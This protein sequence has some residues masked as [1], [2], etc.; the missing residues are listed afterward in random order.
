MPPAENPS[1]S[2]LEAFDFVVVVLYVLV[3]LG[4]VYRA[5]RHQHNTDD[6]FLGSRKMP[7]MAVGLSIM[8]TL[9]SSLTYLGLTGEVVKNGIAAFMTQAAIIPAAPF[10]LFLF[11]PFF[12]R[13]RFTSAYEYL[14]HRFDFR[15]RLLGGGLF[16]LLRLLW[17]SMVMYSGSLALAN[18]GGWNFYGTIAILGIVATLY[19]YF[20]GLEG[21]IWTDVIQA[22]MLFGGAAAIVL[23][24]WFDTGHGPLAWWQVAG[25]HSA[26]HRQ[27]EWFSFDPTKRITLGTALIS[28]FFWQICTHCSDQVVLQRYAS[29]PS[30]AAAR[31]SY[32]T[33]VVA[34]LSIT[35]LLGVSGLALLYYYLQ[36]PDRLPAGLTATS[37][38]DKLMPHFYA[39]QL[40]LGFGGLILANFLCDAMQTLVSGVNSI[41]AVATQD[42]LEHAKAAREGVSNRLGL[43]RRLTLVLGGM[44][45]LIALGVAWL[46]EA[47]G[48]NIFELMP[49]TFNMFIGPLGSLFLI[50]MFLPRATGRTATPAVLGAVAVSVVWNYWKE[51]LSIPLVWHF[52]KHVVQQP[53][54]LSI[55]WAYA[56]AC[57]SGLVFAI[58]LSL[59]FDKGGDHP[60]RA[61]T[62]WAIMQRPLPAPTPE[63]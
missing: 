13:L 48:K 58:V 24:V 45:T 19:T 42:V 61:F 29:T 31:K 28:G 11:I 15:A 35:S 51:I 55:M 44:T 26:A 2:G 12:M 10:V 8:A 3:T 54:D 36:H 5:S 4:I 34:L 59:L 47:S 63:P 41:T 7:W 56:I 39:T 40:P 43:A 30:L 60:G 22:L 6:F 38:G 53:F 9:L 1:L 14:E 21:V 46:A 23:F 33:N 52:A 27:A 62:W 37:A 25:E 17:V 16:F 50:G 57:L 49:K 20:G 32:I 18:M